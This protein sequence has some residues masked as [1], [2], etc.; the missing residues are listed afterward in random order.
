MTTYELLHRR[1]KGAVI[2]VNSRQN[3]LDLSTNK[4]DITP[5]EVIGMVQSFHITRVCLGSHRIE[6]ASVLILA[7]ID[8]DRSVLLDAHSRLCSNNTHTFL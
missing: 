5:S 2:A 3:S 4:M 1:I 6:L 7:P 8:H